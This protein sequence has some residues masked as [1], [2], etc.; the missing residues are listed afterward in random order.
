MA[1]VAWRR[2]ITSTLLGQKLRLFY[3]LG[4]CFVLFVS[5]RLS[6]LNCGSTVV[7]KLIR[8]R[9]VDFADCRRAVDN[10]QRGGVNMELRTVDH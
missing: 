10:P 8:S 5:L 3:N 2:T 4:F 9:I 6:H 7:N 1:Y